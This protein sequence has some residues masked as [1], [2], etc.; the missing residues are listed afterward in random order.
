MAWRRFRSYAGRAR[1]WG[2]RRMAGYRR[3]GGARGMTKIGLPYIGGA[4][5]GYLAPRIHPAQDVAITI[6]AIAPIRLPYNLQ[7][8]AKGYVLGTI[9]KSFIPSIG[10]VNASP[11]GLDFA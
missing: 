1:S 5:L 4:A 6:L 7:N 3:R 9:A 10:G 2:G 11:G 8:I